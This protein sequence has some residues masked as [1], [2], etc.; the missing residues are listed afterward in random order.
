MTDE[1]KAAINRCADQE[2]G[3]DVTLVE[4]GG[5]VGDIEMHAVAVGDVDD[6]CFLAM[7]DDNARHR[8]G[9]AM[10]VPLGM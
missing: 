9:D 4:I 3:I 2:K 7:H 6:D 1:I 5:T 10:H 8:Q